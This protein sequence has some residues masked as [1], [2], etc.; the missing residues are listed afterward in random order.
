M[1]GWSGLAGSLRLMGVIV[2]MPMKSTM[3][4]L[5]QGSEGSEGTGFLLYSFSNPPFSLFRFAA[6][7]EKNRGREKKY[8]RK[9]LPSLPS[10]PS[11]RDHHHRQADRLHLGSG[12]R[13]L[14]GD[15]YHRQTVTMVPSLGLGR[16]RPWPISRYNFCGEITNHSTWTGPCSGTLGAGAPSALTQNSPGRLQG[17]QRQWN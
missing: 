15:H 9:P 5:M 2:E 4:I 7:R 12:D 10:M 8:N 16:R 17:Q 3:A 11:G 1:L 13:H 6:L 14:G